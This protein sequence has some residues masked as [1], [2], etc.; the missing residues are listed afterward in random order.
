MRKLLTIVL[1]IILAAA[2]ILAGIL[3]IG[4]GTFKGFRESDLRAP[5]YSE[6]ERS[7]G[8]P[9]SPHTIVRQETDW[10]IEWSIADVYSGF[11]GIL[12]LSVNN[13][14]PRSIWVYG[15]AFT[16]T[17]TST[18]YERE[19]AVLCPPDAKTEVGL[20]AFGVP[21]SPG[22]H[23]YEIWL[24]V[25][26]KQLTGDAWYD[27]GRLKGGTHDIEIKAAGPPLEWQTSR[28]PTRY[29]NEVNAR[30]SA[31]DVDAV[32]R[33]I[34]S[35]YPGEY[36]ILQVCQAYEWVRRNIA[37]EEETGDYWQSAKETLAR[38]AGDCEDH[39]IL[40]ASIILNLGGNARVN[41]IKAHAFP[42]V[43]VGRNASEVERIEDAIESFYYLPKDAL[44]IN[45][46][47]DEFGYWMVIDTV[48]YAYAGGLPAESR[49]AISESG[50]TW[51]FQSSDY[52]ITVDAT[53]ASVGLFGIL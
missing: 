33:S 51:T 25:A 24:S 34:R 2:L 19:A 23:R 36:N 11:G 32:A 53:G 31:S 42:T 37:Y 4:F 41:I 20:V 43:F 22:I 8:R 28:N 1:V 3:F 21:V 44:R 12:W 47:I 30:I 13:D 49:Y 6:I 35:Q 45:Y 48:G 27:Y 50:G 10:G 14:G 9:P 26:V 29:Y 17:G 38:K 52:L 46:L 40:L 39:A 15:V 18:I 7:E 16:W 5:L